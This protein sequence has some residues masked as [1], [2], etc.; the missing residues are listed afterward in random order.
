M[1]LDDRRESSNLKVDGAQGYGGATCYL[2]GAK[3][4]VTKCRV[5]MEEHR[6]G[7]NER[8]LKNKKD[9]I[10]EYL[11]ELDQKGKAYFEII[12]DQVL[13]LKMM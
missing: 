9:Q 7:I 4:A 2:R 11:I 1:F 12:R 3:G 13:A 5:T 8:M 6:I 10:F